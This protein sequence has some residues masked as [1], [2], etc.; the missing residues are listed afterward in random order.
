MV[1]RNFEPKRRVRN[2]LNQVIICLVFQVGNLDFILV[3][4]PLFPTPNQSLRPD[5]LPHFSC[6]P[7]YPRPSE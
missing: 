3:Y 1:G 2:A 4:C 5:S 7:P 6:V